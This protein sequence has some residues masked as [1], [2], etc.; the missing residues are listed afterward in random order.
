MEIHFWILH[1]FALI[2]D[3]SSSRIEDK[4][5]IHILTKFSGILTKFSSILLNYVKI[6][7]GSNIDFISKD[8][9]ESCCIDQSEFCG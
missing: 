2:F 3:L 9:K 6:V 1:V 5:H 8:R 4:S 7:T